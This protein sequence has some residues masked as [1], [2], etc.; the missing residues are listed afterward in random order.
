MAA[1]DYHTSSHFGDTVDTSIF[2][3]MELSSK[4]TLRCCTGANASSAS[5]KW[6][7]VYEKNGTKISPDYMCFCQ[8]CGENAFTSDEVWEISWKDYNN[9]SSSHSCMMYNRHK[10]LPYVGDRRGMCYQGIKVN[11]N[12]VSEDDKLWAPLTKM[13]TDKAK[14]A[15]KNG[16]LM[17]NVPTMSYWEFVVMGDEFCR[18]IYQHNYYFKVI[19]KDGTGR[20]IKIADQAGNTNFYSPMTNNMLKVNAFGPEK[21]QRFFFQAPSQLEQEHNL[22]ASH[23]NESNKIYLTIEIY[24]KEEMPKTLEEPGLY[25]GGQTRGTTRGGQTRGTTR[26]GSD[27]TG[28]SNFASSGTA[29][30]STTHM[31]YARF[32]KIKSIDCIIQLVNNESEEERIYFAKKLQDQIDTREK[33][34]YNTVNS[35]TVNSRF[36]ISYVYDHD[37]ESTSYK[38]SRR[39]EILNHQDQEAFLI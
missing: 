25:R 31:T 36:D 7:G 5:K 19:A 8:Y 28:G 34:I 39:S 9:F 35:R 14:L 15:E 32:Q 3:P 24:R 33:Q 26:G 17:A 11:V 21:G 30:T 10:C 18:G 22:E 12:V 23:N 16:V 1:S 38:P 20:T 13:T 4:Q 27:Y 6:Y 2:N 29:H 37:E